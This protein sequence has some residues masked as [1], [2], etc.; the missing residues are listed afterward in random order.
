MV[1][2]VLQNIAKQRDVRRWSNLNCAFRISLIGMGD[3]KKCAVN[4]PFC[5]GM[6]DFCCCDSDDC[7][8]EKNINVQRKQLS[9]GKPGKPPCHHQSDLRK[10][11][12]RKVQKTSKGRIPANATRS[13]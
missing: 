2:S 8:A 6:T 5:L 12:A 9:S 4:F 11:S 13:T 3:F 1:T 7:V 10:P